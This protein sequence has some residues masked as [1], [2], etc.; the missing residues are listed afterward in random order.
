M[1]N[2]VMLVYL[3]VLLIACDWIFVYS[4]SICQIIFIARINLMR[5]SW[6][7]WGFCSCCKGETC[8]VCIYFKL[9]MKIDFAFLAAATSL[10]GS[11][12]RRIGSTCFP[13][14]H[15]VWLSA[16]PSEHLASR[17]TVH[18]SSLED[19]LVYHV[20][21]MSFGIEAREMDCAGSSR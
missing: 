1:F 3:A 5:S 16:L 20:R 19:C 13:P 17:Q 10:S 14:A 2:V 18:L 15:V 11:G 6:L 12:Q 7:Y 4:C 21:L 8:S 9:L